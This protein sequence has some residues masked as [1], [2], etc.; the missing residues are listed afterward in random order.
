MSMNPA[1]PGAAPRPIYL[2]AIQPPVRNRLT[3]ALRFI[4]AIPQLFVLIFVYIAAFFVAIVGWF[5]ALVTGELPD[6][7]ENFLSGTLRWGV[8]VNGYL[9]FLTDS[10]PPYS[11]DEDLNYPIH[12]AFPGRAPLN[13]L[14][15]LFRIILVIPASI[16]GSVVGAGLGIVSVGSWAMITFTG[17]LPIPLYEAT[18]AVSRFQLRLGGYF[19]MLTPEYP[20]GL[21][22]DLPPTDDEMT[23]QSNDWSIRLSKGG[24]NAMIVVIVLGIIETIVSRR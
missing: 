6:F 2:H 20:W 22:G 5:A 14:A 9:Y 3:A 1:A 16:V 19:L 23:A 17:R 10:Y 11:I 13:R 18:R 21:L 4:W 7:A 15:V 8:R 24:R 12:I